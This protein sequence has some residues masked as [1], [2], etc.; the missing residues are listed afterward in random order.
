MVQF[1]LMDK[2]G[3]SKAKVFIMDMFSKGSLMEKELSNIKI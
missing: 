3:S 2:L 1:H